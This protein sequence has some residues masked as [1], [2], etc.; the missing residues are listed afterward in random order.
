MKIFFVL[1][2]LI[3]L[4]LSLS[5]LKRLPLTKRK[6]SYQ[7]HHNKSKDATTKK[8]HFSASIKL[9]DY[10]LMQY[11]GELKIG[12]SLDTYELIF[13]TGSS[14][15]W[16][17]SSRCFS[18]KECGINTFFDCSSSDSCDSSSSVIEISYGSG[19]LQGYIIQDTVQIGDYTSDDQSLVDV[20]K[21]QD[22]SSFEAD[23]I[24]GL[25]L[26]S[27]SN[28]VNTLV[29]NLK[30]DDQISNRIFSIYLGGKNDSYP[31]QFTL[32]GYDSRLIENGSNLSYCSLVGQDYWSISINSLVLNGTKGNHIIFNSSNNS[33]VEAVIDSG[34]SLLVVDYE[35]FRNL[36]KFLNLYVECEYLEG[37][38]LCKNSSNEIYPDIVVNLCGKEY[39]LTSED[40]LE[41]YQNYYIVLAESTDMNYVILG[42]VFMRKIYTVFDIENTQIGFAVAIRGGPT[43]EWIWAWKSKIMWCWNIF[44]FL[45]IVLI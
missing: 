35:T 4:Q 16:V 45:L 12:S 38:I 36:Y 40:Y 3:L 29:E 31:A 42:D 20:S 25:G 11:T 37:Y 23:G 27:L 5:K 21:V 28:G 32:D 34:T 22:F 39:V 13:D 43:V 33:I 10:E 17:A 30:T 6:A 18:C 14:Y 26:E 41:K 2:I 24:L 15:L 9:T 1:L 19:S 44:V 7:K 8:N